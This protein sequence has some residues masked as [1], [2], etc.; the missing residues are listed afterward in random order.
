[1]LEEW[2]KRFREKEE[3]LHFHR[4]RKDLIWLDVGEKGTNKAVVDLINDNYHGPVTTTTLN[5][6][7]TSEFPPTIELHQG[8]TFTNYLLS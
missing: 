1:M 3:H 5:G 2:R 8:L 7:K 4:F 6:R